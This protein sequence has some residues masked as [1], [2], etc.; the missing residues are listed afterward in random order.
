[1]TNG[2]KIK[3]L[4]LELTKTPSIV[5]TSGEAIIAQEIYT[6]FANLDYFRQH[7]DQL[8]LL[9]V[10]GDALGRCT[11]LAYIEGGQK[12][13][14]AQA[15]T[16]T[17]LCLGHVDTAGIED[18]GDLS[19]YAASPEE[20]REKLRS[21]Q[22]SENTRQEIDS[23]DWIMGRGIFDMKTGVAA[24]MVMIAE[25]AQSAGQLAG[26]LA[27]IGVPDEEGSSA[28]M[29][30]AAL[31]LDQLS[32]EKG[33]D[34]IA[35]V[36][37][38]YMT[39][40]FPGDEN[41]YVYIGTVGKLLPSFYIYGEETHVGEAFNGLDAN[42]LSAEI[43]RHID[44]N[45]ELSDIAD[46]EVTQPPVCLK[47]RD[48][49]KEYTVQTANAV[50]L[51]FNHATHSSLPAA[52]LAK[53]KQK[54]EAAFTTVIRRLNKEYE[55]FCRLSGI[56]HRQL[57]WQAQVLTY[58][59]LYQAVR[60]ETGDKI[61]SLIANL[62]QDLLGKKADDREISLAI[63]EQVHKL[64]SNQNSK[65]I[66]YF[67]PPYYP[68]AFVTG[69]TEKE[70]RLLDII[71]KVVKEAQAAYQYNIMTKKFYPYISDL[72]Y[73]SLSHNEEVIDTLTA[74]MPAWSRSYSLPLQAIQ[75]LNM[76][77]VNI[78]PYGKDAHKLS[79]RLSCR[80]SLDAMPFIL[81]RT[82]TELLK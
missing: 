13:A 25:F 59:E 23:P 82:L 77:V 71:G 41:K 22:F 5:G 33:W 67:S 32:R 42:L 66:L 78:G 57:P 31:Y 9:P 7:P 16:K 40:R 21:I 50:A 44:L 74:N 14:E 60:K 8:Q 62:V 6:Y 47:Q 1:M 11:V 45:T 38:D 10:P 81:A 51:Y 63:V 36:D 3:A 52:V 30:S 34:F 46:G 18:F 73:C 2:E 53:Y 26:N 56:P 49:K 12:P 27:F 17:V 28:G 80:Y 72:S 68:H 54:A 65:V 61:D 79:E 37:T 20:L 58:D 29:L 76:P 39:D 55:S 43:L 70:K 19:A 64:Y 15:K 69:Q 48:L 24:L 75:N 35:A 4:A